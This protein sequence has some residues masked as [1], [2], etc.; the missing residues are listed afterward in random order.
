MRVPRLLARRKI[1][2]LS[3]A[4][5]AAVSAVG[6]VLGNADDAVAVP[7]VMMA[8]ASKPPL[9]AAARTVREARASRL[10]AKTAS[11]ARL[12]TTLTARA[13]SIDLPNL[14]HP[15]VESWIKRFTTDLRSSYATDFDRMS[16]YGKMI[17]AKLA[18]RGM[19]QSLVYLAMIESGFN[20]SARSPV[21]ASGLWQFMGATGRQYGLT[22]NR[23]VDERNNPSR[24]TDA[25]LTYLSAL[26]DQFGSWYLAAAAYNSGPGTV[27][28]A[29]KR[30]T[31]RT[32]GTD[33]DYYRISHALPQ[34]TRD[35]V[36]KM[37]AA[38]RIGSNP[39][40]YGF[41]VN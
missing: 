33:A 36:P 18:N 6:I 25:A 5:I 32:R 22:V 38:A 2:T 16:R 41:G 26:H 3:L 11:P 27:S 10:A 13:R 1:E 29:M 17:S 14:E 19:P 8:R 20:P 4:A 35:Y 31:G 40:K 21:Q 7:S 28:K 37:I 23:K 15:R 9:G 30:V 24:S 34:E 12:R 39:L